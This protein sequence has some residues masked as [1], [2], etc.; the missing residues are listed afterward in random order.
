MTKRQ[1]AM[2]SFGLKYSGH[3]G[4]NFGTYKTALEAFETFKGFKPFAA[5]NIDEKDY[6]NFK[7]GFD[8]GFQLR[9][10]LNQKLMDAQNTAFEY[11]AEVLK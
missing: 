1:Y 10:E 5:L 3:G 7:A 11:L 6:P 4:L 8:Y 2:Q 9:T